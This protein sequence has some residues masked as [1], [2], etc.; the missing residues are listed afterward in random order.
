MHFCRD[1]LTTVV[2]TENTGT[3]TIVPYL[4]KLA[5]C[6]TTWNG[7]RENFVAAI[8]HHT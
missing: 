5:Q 3:I 4:L 2:V 8:T 6:P 7:L 1:V